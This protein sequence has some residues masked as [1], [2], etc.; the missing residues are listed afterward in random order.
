MKKSISILT[1]FMGLAAIGAHTGASASIKKDAVMNIEN[2][3]R[4]T[5]QTSKFVGASNANPYK[6][7]RTPK[8]NQRQKRKLWRQVGHMRKKHGK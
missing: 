2:I 1:A 6:H 5:A 8:F 4:P 7:I 3:K